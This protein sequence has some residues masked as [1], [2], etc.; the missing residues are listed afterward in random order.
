MRATGGPQPAP[1]CWLGSLVDGDAL[2][3][4]AGYDLNS[5][6]GYQ[7]AEQTTDVLHYRS[8]CIDADQ[9]PPLAAQLR[10][11]LRDDVPL[12]SLPLSADSRTGSTRR[13]SRCSGL[14][15]AFCC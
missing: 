14:L 3:P 7:D 13:L 1:R 11:G 2:G 9:L 10:D 6:R 12:L 5:L 8:A 15:S 4:G